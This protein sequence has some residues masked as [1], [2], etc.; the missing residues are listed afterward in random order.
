[1]RRKST[2]SYPENWN[3]IAQRVKDEANWHCIR[4]GRFHHPPTGYTLTVHHLDLNPSNC[5]WW[6][7]AALCQRCH[8][9]IQAKVIMERTWLLPHTEWFKPYVAGFYAFIFGKNDERDY[10]MAHVDELIAMGQGRE[11][12][13]A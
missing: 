12:V 10:V 6:N 9:Q 3:E 11:V 7:L 8:L 2:S 1:M 5:K 4:C 13:R